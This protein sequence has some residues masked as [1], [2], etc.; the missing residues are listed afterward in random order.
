M[1]SQK[2]YSQ[3]PHLYSNYAGDAIH[4]IQSANKLADDSV[5]PRAEP[6]AGDNGCVHLIGLE[7]HPLPWSG[8]PEMGAPRTGLMNNNLQTVMLQG[9]APSKIALHRFNSLFT[10]GKKSHLLRDGVV[11]VDE[12]LPEMI[13]KERS[14]LEHPCLDGQEPNSNGTKME[15]GYEESPYLTTEY[16]VL[17]WRGFGY[18][19][20]S[21]ASSKFSNQQTSRQKLA[22]L[23]AASEIE[24]ESALKFIG[25][26]NPFYYKID[27]Q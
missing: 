6:S 26:T 7:I 5:E 23:H 12:I 17:S 13:A 16:A 11:R 18:V 9:L 21:I 22:T 19:C 27:M 24:F 4:I 10:K 14:A 3:T 25:T 2:D 20:R 15:A 8:T 1:H